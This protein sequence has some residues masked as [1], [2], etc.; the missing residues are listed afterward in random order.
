[1]SEAQGAPVLG[2]VGLRDQ[3]NGLASRAAASPA[4]SAVSSGMVAGDSSVR[5]LLARGASNECDLQSC[6]LQNSSKMSGR[7]Q[8]W[9]PGRAWRVVGPVNGAGVVLRGRF[10][11][12][13]LTMTRRAFLVYPSRC[14][15]E[16]AWQSRPAL[17]KH[18][19]CAHAHFRVLRED[20]KEVCGGVEP[21]L[22]SPASPG[23]APLSCWRG[24][25]SLVR[26]PA[27]DR[28]VSRSSCPNL[29]DHTPPI[30][31]SPPLPN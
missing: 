23:T 28:I 22:C 1:V 27:L 20:V 30:S 18:G 9:H 15:L 13:G 16:R 4:E 26:R 19:N 31:S 6:I 7:G 29:L 24:V 2:I 12:T 25:L 8:R 11:F 10:R 14:L 3:T 17:Y 5:F 21:Y